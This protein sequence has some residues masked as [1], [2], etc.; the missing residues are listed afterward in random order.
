[1]NLYRVSGNHKK[2]GQFTAG[3]CVDAKNTVWK[4]APILRWM[5]EKP[6]SFVASY[7]KNQGWQLEACE[8]S[9]NMGR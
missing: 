2:L 1:M 9:A 3:F 4:A 7:C 8:Q 6:F 5:Q